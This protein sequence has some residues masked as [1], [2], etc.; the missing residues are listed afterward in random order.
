MPLAKTLLA[1]SLAFLRAAPL[2]SLPSGAAAHHGGVAGGGAANARTGHGGWQAGGV[3]S[4]PGG[5][6]QDAARNASL[7][8]ARYAHNGAR[9]KHGNWRRR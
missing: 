6:E 1:R 3:R 2:P 7:L 4:S 8:A 9:A 5:H